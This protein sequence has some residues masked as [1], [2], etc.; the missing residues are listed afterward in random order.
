VFTDLASLPNPH[1]VKGAMKKNEERMATLKL[2]DTANPS[3]QRYGR[4]PRQWAL[5]KQDESANQEKNLI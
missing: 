1:H 5:K 4:W 2:E 3:W